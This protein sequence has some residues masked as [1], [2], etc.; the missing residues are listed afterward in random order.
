MSTTEETEAVVRD[1]CAQFAQADTRLQELV[2][3]KLLSPVRAEH[4]RVRLDQLRS[5]AASAPLD[6]VEAA[7]LAQQFLQLACEIWLEPIPPAS[8]TQM[9]A[10]EA[11]LRGEVIRLAGEHANLEMAIADIERFTGEHSLHESDLQAEFEDRTMLEARL[12]DVKDGLDAIHH[13][14]VQLGLAQ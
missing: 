9:E 6:D 2:A 14:R 13:I 5:E 1:L 11:Y 10:I 4:F 3:R 8:E 12:K 7:H